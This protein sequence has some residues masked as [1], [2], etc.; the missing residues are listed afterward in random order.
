MAY[1]RN[2]MIAKVTLKSHGTKERP[3]GYYHVDLI[4][5]MNLQKKPTYDDPVN[6]EADCPKWTIWLGC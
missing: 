3:S 4:L 1:W 5:W 2:E 6:D